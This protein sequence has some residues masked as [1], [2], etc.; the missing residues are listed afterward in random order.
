MV[1]PP[2]QDVDSRPLLLNGHPM[3]PL[4]LSRLECTGGPRKKWAVSNSGAWPG[5]GTGLSKPL[6]AAGER[7][8]AGDCVWGEQEGQAGH[9]GPRRGLAQEPGSASSPRIG[10]PG[11]H[12]VRESKAAPGFPHK[13]V[14]SLPPGP[15]HPPEQAGWDTS[16]Q[17]ATGRESDHWDA[18]VPDGLLNIPLSLYRLCCPDLLIN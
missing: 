14:L 3:S 9:P 5:A 15:W 8:Q 17:E 12:R 7:P 13:A 4:H 2:H 10:A 11:V 18:Q 1:A 16:G 6:W